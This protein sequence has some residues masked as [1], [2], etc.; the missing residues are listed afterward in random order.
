[1]KVFSLFLGVFALCTLQAQNKQK[2]IYFGPATS[3]SYQITVNGAKAETNLGNFGFKGYVQPEIGLA[4]KYQ[5]DST[6]FALVSIS[7]S[8][9][10]YTL[11]ANTILRNGL[12]NYAATDRF[13]V[14][15]N[16]F[17]MKLSYHRSIAHISPAFSFNLE[18]GIGLHYLRTYETMTSEDTIISPYTIV[19]SLD[20]EKGN[21]FLPS[22]EVG[23][24][25]LVKPMTSKAQVIFGL[26]SNLYLDNFSE[27]SYTST[28]TNGTAVSNNHFRWAPTLLVPE[29]YAAVLF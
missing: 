22:L 27:V 26:R 15:M 13:D 29:V 12:S 14:F 3:A 10:A 11:S 8:K 9:I 17:S 18:A 2:R 7:A 19:H 28:Y 1:M 23:M 5:Q 4:F 24:N 21:F 6:E 16:Q 25:M 20:I